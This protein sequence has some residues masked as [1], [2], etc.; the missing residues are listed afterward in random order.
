VTQRSA[1]IVRIYLLLAEGVQSFAA[2]LLG[3]DGVR[4]M[5]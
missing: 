5:G 3:L 1:F 2:V 4:R